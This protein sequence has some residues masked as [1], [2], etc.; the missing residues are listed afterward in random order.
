LLPGCFAASVVKN[1]IAETDRD[2]ALAV[3]DIWKYFQPKMLATRKKPVHDYKVLATQLHDYPTL[4]LEQE[5]ERRVGCRRIRS[6][7]GRDC[8]ILLIC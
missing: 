3:V 7:N 4:R 8:G 1:V 2:P 6:C 5:I